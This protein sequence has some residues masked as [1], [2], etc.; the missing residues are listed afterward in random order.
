MTQT[1]QLS[2]VL[3]Q[4][5]FLSTLLLT[6]TIPVEGL[7]SKTSSL[8]PSHPTN[9]MPPSSTSSQSNFR[10]VRI[11]LFFKD[12]DELV[13][14][15]QFFK[16]YGI[17][18]FNLVNKHVKD[19]IEEWV[20]VI[21]EELVDCDICAHFSLRY[22][23]KGRRNVDGAY[24]VFSDF[25]ASMG[26]KCSGG[27][28]VEILLISGAGN[29]GKLDSVETLKRRKEERLQPKMISS[30]MMMTPTSTNHPRIAVAFN[31]FFP[32]REEDEKE[33]QRLLQ[34]L[35][36][37]QVSKVYIQFGT[38]IQRL[39]SSLEWLTNLQHNK[40]G[41]DNESPFNF[42][43]CGSIFLPTSKLIAQQKFR[44]WK[45]V[46]LCD[47]FLSG[48]LHV[49]EDIV[50]N[51]LKLYEEHGAEIL[52]EAP[53][54]RNEKDM[55]LV[56]MLLKERDLVMSRDNKVGED[57]DVFMMKKTRK[58]KSNKIVVKDIKNSADKSTPGKNSLKF[59]PSPLV[60]QSALEAT[61]ILLFG[62]FDVRLRDN[63]ALQLASHHS[64]I[65]PVFLWS[66]EEQQK[67]GVRGAI[68]VVLKD[69]LQN[70]SGQLESHGL[71][72]IC[73]NTIDSTEELASLC[74]EVGAKTVYWN[75]EQTT[76]SRALE[77]RRKERLQQNNGVTV[78]ECQSS[79]LY[80]VEKMSLS[81]GFHGGH[82]GTLM[83]FLKG[84]KKQF[85]EPKRPSFKHETFAILESLKEKVSS[86]VEE[87]SFEWPH[88]I[89][90]EDLDMAVIT[91]T[92][93]W[94]VPIL[95]RFSPMSEESASTTLNEFASKGLPFYEIERSRADLEWST[96]KLSAH[97]R[98]GTISPNEVYYKA[99]DSASLSPEEIKT[100]WRRLVWRD[101]AY[102]QLF[103]FPL[104]RETSIRAHYENTE[105]V[106]GDEEKRRL[107]AWKWG[108]TGYPIVDAGMRELYETGWMTQSVRM[109]AA[110][111][112]TE[113]LRVNWVKGC[114]WFHYTLVDADSAINAMMWQNAG[115][116]GID[117]W[118]FV[119]SPENASQD[120]SG[121]Y[122]KRW[123]P[124]LS[125]LPKGVIHRPW[126]A[127]KAV[128][129][130]EGIV[131]GKT[132]PHRIVK[133]LK[134]ERAKSVEHV[135]SM[136]RSSQ[137]FNNERGYDL[138]T[139]P[140]GE[141]TVVFTKKEYRLD[142]NGDVFVKSSSSKGGKGLYKKKQ[143]K[144]RIRSEKRQRRR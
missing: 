120:S 79:L 67:W 105:W 144:I 1:I 89:Q 9:S 131:L 5:I 116:S 103:T 96:S 24:G 136:R 111:F 135:L 76:E 143:E 42:T 99:M 19:P 51:M 37:H 113:Y 129:E 77:K 30:S 60:S 133:N 23:K 52:I 87:R 122:T 58:E 139:L 75:R 35:Q 20:D 84:C 127:P 134:E 106:T 62:S 97:L 88:G 107:E 114:E 83:P 112:L 100:F 115:R 28:D 121:E 13:Q 101:L 47:D 14:R 31:P 71:R 90:V 142:Q 36:T 102:Y 65:I 6:C 43:I 45:G 17:T 38:N 54:V 44:P 86:A 39:H 63:E 41:Q 137:Q 110:S 70:L 92:Q 123:V 82:W 80:D 55:E 81:T 59:K 2:Y 33:K 53:G 73:R 74:K 61:A 3:I 15:T 117:Q 68:E 119:M 69:A 11:E 128:L 104:M 124:E 34:K 126:Q 8:P 7:A 27:K 94:D 109:I 108:K 4:L 16:K 140:N 48:D 22:Q 21:Q 141:R 29:F 91:G 57:D 125:S 98:I 132:Y 10:N 32:S 64:S 138:I 18:S 85:G 95:E 66:K 56:K 93:R 49:A 72:L 50:V 26:Q 118:N 40:Q 12:N 25:C 130:R 78:V 46:Y